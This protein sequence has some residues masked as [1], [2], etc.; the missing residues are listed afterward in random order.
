MD[1]L[2]Q[3]WLS[4]WC[5]AWQWADEGWLQVTAVEPDI[6][7]W[8]ALMRS[9]HQDFMVALGIQPET[10]PVV[11]ADILHWGSLSPLQRDRAL[12][13][14]ACICCFPG[15]TGTRLLV[16]EADW[17]RQVAK[18]LRP[19]QWIGPLYLDVRLLLGAWLGESYWPRI[20]LYWPP[21]Q[22]GTLVMPTL[23]LPTHKLEALWCAVFW[24]VRLI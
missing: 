24:R 3:R 10:P 19:G 14:A 5:Q 17:C 4:W 7:L 18:A 15:V 6:G 9:R 13:L 21:D 22:V 16:A 8:P 12:A 20:R 1:D 2:Q 23:A 11:I